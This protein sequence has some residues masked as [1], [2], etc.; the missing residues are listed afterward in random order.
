MQRLKVQALCLEDRFTF[1]QM[2]PRV[3]VIT[4]T[5]KRPGKN[6]RL[7]RVQTAY[8]GF[9]SHAEA[10]R[11]VQ[12]ITYY[13]LATFAELRTPKRLAGVSFEVKVRGMDEVMIE[14]LAQKDLNRTPREVYLESP[15]ANDS[16]SRVQVTDFDSYPVAP[17]QRP[18]TFRGVSID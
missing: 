7:A 1:F 14:H 17:R 4:K 13:R 10:S 12:Y 2:S 3:G 6:G 9:L 5:L 16:F 18:T 15:A 8:F 11:F